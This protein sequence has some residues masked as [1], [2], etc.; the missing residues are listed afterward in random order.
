MLYFSATEGING[1]ELWKS[2][3]TAGGTVLFKDIFAGVGSSAPSAIIAING[4]LLFRANDGLNGEE[5]WRIDGTAG[6]TFMR[7]DV[8]I[9]GGSNPYSFTQSGPLTYAVFTT[10]EYGSELWVDYTTIILPVGL[11]DFNGQLQ[12]SNALLNW[13]TANEKNTRSF[14]LE[15]STDGRNYTAVYNVAAFNTAGAH[16]YNFID[17]NITAL[18]AAVIYYRLKQVDMDGGFTYSHIVALSPA[19]KNIVLFYPNPVHDRATLAITVNKPQQVHYRIIDNAG[20]IISEQKRNVV[21]GSNSFPINVM[22]LAKGMYWL[23]LK[24]ETINEQRSFIKQ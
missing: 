10:E 12:N 19:G 24:G 11:L 20:R 1:Y 15:R 14:V 18:N 2:D 5:V 13:K 16:Q 4:K 17:P 8:A 3:G 9:P 22:G 23:E 7:A 6:G 21:T